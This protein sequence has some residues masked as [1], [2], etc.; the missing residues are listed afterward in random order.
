MKRWR[1]RLT[2][3]RRRNPY[4]RQNCGRGWSEP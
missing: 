1:L 2:E 4:A 3:L